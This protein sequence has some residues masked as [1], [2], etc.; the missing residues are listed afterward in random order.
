MFQTETVTID[1]LFVGFRM[2]FGKASAKFNFFTIHSDRA[3]STLSFL[4]DLCGYIFIIHTQKPTDA[5]M[6]FV[7]SL[8]VSMAISGSLLSGMPYSVRFFSL[9]GLVSCEK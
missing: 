4:F 5:G 6:L 8:S 2:K 3:I 1:Y 7:A 9:D